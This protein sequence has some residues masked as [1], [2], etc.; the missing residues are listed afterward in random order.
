MPRQF[1]STRPTGRE[2]SGAA[3]DLQADIERATGVKPE[4]TKRNQQ[5]ESFLGRSFYENTTNN[6]RI[7]SFRQS[8]NAPGKHILKITM[9]DPTVQKI[10]IHDSDLPYS[11]FGPPESNLNG[12]AN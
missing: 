8:V 9:V 11:Y 10:I 4:F 12:A 7:M 5:S 6:A 1:L 3:S 2:S